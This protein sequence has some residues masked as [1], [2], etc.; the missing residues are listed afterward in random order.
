LEYTIEGIM[1]DKLKKIKSDIEK[2]ILKM[3]SEGIYGPIG[4]L[5]SCLDEI[6]M[7]VEEVN[8]FFADEEAE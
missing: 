7:A 5:E 1:L 3:D 4:F 2:L 8:L 6:E